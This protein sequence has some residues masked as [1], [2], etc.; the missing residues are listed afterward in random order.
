MINNLLNVYCDIY[1]IYWT[2]GDLGQNIKQ[3]AIRKQNIPCR[4]RQLSKT[5]LIQNDKLTIKSTHRIYFD[6]NGG[7]GIVEGDNIRINNVFYRVTGVNLLHKLINFGFGSEVSHYE[8]DVYIGNPEYIYESSSSSSEFENYSSS[9][10][11]SESSSSSSDYSYLTSDSSES[12]GNDSTSSS[13]SS[14]SSYI[15]NYSS[16]S[17]SSESSSSDSSDSSSSSSATEPVTTTTTTTEVPF[18]SS[19]WLYPQLS[20]NN[21]TEPHIGDDIDLEDINNEKCNKFT[22]IHDNRQYLKYR[23]DKRFQ[24]YDPVKFHDKLNKEN[25]LKIKIRSEKCKKNN[26]EKISKSSESENIIKR[27]QNKINEKFVNRFKN[28]K[29]EI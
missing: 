9:S 26:K 13:D 18:G 29:E 20:F 3:F 24:H 25:E 2:V 10:S 21:N 1:S 5:E 22:E 12:I 8:V 23:N 6:Y 4:I 15:E 11:S 28:K 14:S 17:D 19:N 7:T 16:S 27:I